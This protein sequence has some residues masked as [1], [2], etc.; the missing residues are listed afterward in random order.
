MQVLKYDLNTRNNGDNK[1]TESVPAESKPKPQYHHLTERIKA[2]LKGL[3]GVSNNHTANNATAAT[4]SDE[5]HFTANEVE[6]LEAIKRQYK[7]EAKL[8]HP[9]MGGTA[10]T[11]TQLNHSYE[12]IREYINK[13]GTFAEIRQTLHQMNDTGNRD[14]EAQPR[15]ASPRRHQSPK[16]PRQPQ[17]MSND[18][19]A[20]W[21]RSSRKRVREL[22]WRI[23]MRQ[24]EFQHKKVEKIKRIIA[25][26]QLWRKIVDDPQD[27]YPKSYVPKSYPI[28][29][30]T[31]AVN[32]QESSSSGASQSDHE[33]TARDHDSHTWSVYESDIS[34]YSNFFNQPSEKSCKSSGFSN[35]GGNSSSTAKYYQNVVNAQKHKRT[36][37]DEVRRRFVRA[38]RII[39][40]ISPT[41]HLLK[42]DDDPE[43]YAAIIEDQTA[44]E[45]LF[46]HLRMSTV[47]KRSQ[48]MWELQGQ[49]QPLHSA[50][51]SEISSAENNQPLQSA[52]NCSST[53][54]PGG[55]K[56]HGFDEANVK[57]PKLVRTPPPP[58]PPPKP[59]PKRP[60]QIISC[61]GVTATSSV[62]TSTSERSALRTVITNKIEDNK[63]ANNNSPFE[64]KS[65]K[66][67]VAAADFNSAQKMNESRRKKNHHS[68]NRIACY[69]TSWPDH[70]EQSS[71]AQISAFKHDGDNRTQ[72]TLPNKGEELWLPLPNER[73]YN[74]EIEGTTRALEKV[75][76]S[77]PNSH[78]LRL[79]SAYG[80]RRKQLKAR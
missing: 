55:E 14:A 33:Q 38:S 10:A 51:E 60:K 21:I 41:D 28:W 20:Q 16:Q 19:T 52:A 63:E 46:N 4:Y 67:I 9:D 62:A 69:S 59:P 56:I 48:K 73:R 27:N 50:T 53:T 25:K 66:V 78:G 8:H 58:P 29:P 1:N 47:R 17:T 35:L 43:L 40:D 18:A 37:E 31:P 61:Q 74:D 77:K 32:S 64:T 15:V 13:G 11:M 80:L 42:A 24:K 5:R 70:L 65:C 36:V 71:G 75:A 23:S 54:R 76:V 34:A 57:Q 6:T 45:T 79:G 12:R 72:T 26:E 3:K 49:K 44:D 68:D 2:T 7:A 22:R 30:S 39:E